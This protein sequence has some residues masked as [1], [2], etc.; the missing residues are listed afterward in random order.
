MQVLTIDGAV[1]VY[2]AIVASLG[3]YAGVQSY[4]S[5]KFNASRR[6]SDSLLARRYLF[7][8]IGDGSKEELTVW[9]ECEYTPVEFAVDQAEDM[10]NDYWADYPPLVFDKYSEA[11]EYVDKFKVHS[12]VKTRGIRMV[13]CKDGVRNMRMHDYMQK[14][15][16]LK[17][18]ES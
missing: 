10:G 14:Q 9:D 11:V 17:D 1:R 18:E 8:L 6:A 7:S 15:R 12:R 13:P 2:D 16:K 5:W 3:K 4:A